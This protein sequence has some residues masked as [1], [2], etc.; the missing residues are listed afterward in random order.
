M[1]TANVQPI[2]NAHPW[3][4]SFARARSPQCVNQAAIFAIF[5]HLHCHPDTGERGASP[6]T[7]GPTQRVEAAEAT[8]GILHE[9]NQTPV[10]RETIPTTGPTQ[11]VEAAEATAS[12]LQFSLHIL[13]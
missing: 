5:C 8:A 4:Y 13:L 10:I 7:T 12:T 1:I 9:S 3:L 6:S 2:P 11:R